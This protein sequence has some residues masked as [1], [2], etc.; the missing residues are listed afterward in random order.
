MRGEQRFELVALVNIP[1]VATRARIVLWH[2][3]KPTNALD[4]TQP[5]LPISFGTTETRTHDYVRRGTT[6]LFAP[7][8]TATGQVYGECRTVRDGTAFLACLTKAIAAG[9]RRAGQPADSHHPD[10][11]NWLKARSLPPHRRRLG[12]DQPDRDLVGITTR[13]AM[14]R[15]LSLRGRPHP[16][17][18]PRLHHPLE[19]STPSRSPGQPQPTKS[20]PGPPHP[21]HASAN[22]STKNAAAVNR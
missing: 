4:R 12:M 6:N 3:Y 10:G 9:S 5:L 19:T 7:L 14:S 11:E 16:P 21:D 15:R 22:S 8:N 13:Q 18:G 20:S 1:D 2:A 17:P